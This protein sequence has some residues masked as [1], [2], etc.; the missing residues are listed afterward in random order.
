[1]TT[2]YDDFHMRQTLLDGFT[3]HPDT[4]FRTLTRDCEH[5]KLSFTNS[6]SYLH[7]EALYD[8]F[9]EGD[10]A[11]W[12]SKPV[13]PWQSIDG[14]Q[15]A[16]ALANLS[17]DDL[18]TV[19]AYGRLAERQ[20][21]LALETWKDTPREA[22]EVIRKLQSC[23]LKIK[24]TEEGGDKTK[25]TKE[26]PKQY[27]KPATANVT[28][29]DNDNHSDD[30][31]DEFDDDLLLTTTVDANDQMANLQAI[32]ETF[33]A[34]V[35]R[36][37]CGMMA[38]MEFIDPE[39]VPDTLAPLERDIHP[40]NSRALLRRIMLNRHLRYHLADS[41]N[42]VEC[43]STWRNCVGGDSLHWE[44]CQPCRVRFQ[45]GKMQPSHRHCCCNGNNLDQTNGHHEG[46]YHRDADMT[47]PSEF[48]CRNYRCT[49]DPV[50]Q[51]HHTTNRLRHT[52][53]QSS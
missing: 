18:S 50:Y 38:Q 4:A 8:Q 30:S 24:A 39:D 32:M 26:I 49:V 12:K 3:K 33:E 34:S 20:D 31:D 53:V 41:D 21:F 43:R 37:L 25:P 27:S 40:S 11:S 2:P 45:M 15:L 17:P 52:A 48:Q 6:C 29:L 42:G 10:T 13:L 14:I 9:L 47:L 22:Q 16:Q 36:S 51:K 35:M 46:A 5:D 7:R 28:K 44:K 1:M 19:I 23:F